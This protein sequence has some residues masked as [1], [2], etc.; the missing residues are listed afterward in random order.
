MKSIFPGDSE[1]NA[2]ESLGNLDE[3]RPVSWLEVIRFENLVN[4]VSNLQSAI[5]SSKHNHKVSSTEDYIY[6]FSNFSNFEPNASQ[7]LEPITL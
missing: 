5:W 4:W 6:F 7:L 2:S 1:S 3:N